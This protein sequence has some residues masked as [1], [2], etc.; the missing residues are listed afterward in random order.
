MSNPGFPHLQIGFQTRLYAPSKCQYCP[1]SG[2]NLWISPKILVLW[3]SSKLVNDRW[4]LVYMALYPFVSYS[5]CWLLKSDKQ[6]QRIRKQPRLLLSLLF[7][8]FYF[9][10]GSPFSQGPTHVFS[11]QVWAS[12]NNFPVKNH[13]PNLRIPR[14]AC[15]AQWIIT[16][17]LWASFLCYRQFFRIDDRQ[18]VLRDLSQF[19]AG[20]SIQALWSIYHA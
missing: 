18:E 9:L 19:K 3:K 13:W 1:L 5:W 7:P 15:Q 4:S 8:E 14:C 16:K 6:R 2:V 10:L 20:L 12:C 11:E 17:F